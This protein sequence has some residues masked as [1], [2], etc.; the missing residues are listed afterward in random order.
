[1][2][3]KE[4]GM[5]NISSLSFFFCYNPTLDKGNPHSGI[6]E[7]PDPPLKRPW[8]FPLI[9]HPCG[10]LKPQTIKRPLVSACFHDTANLQ[11][12]LKE[13]IFHKTINTSK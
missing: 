8:I 6:T 7:P 9:C 1:M 5:S 2:H 12:A 3:E 11:S 4:R 13:T 10:M